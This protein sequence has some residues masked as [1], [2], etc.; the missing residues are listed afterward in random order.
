[1]AAKIKY[2][3]FDLG[4]SKFLSKGDSGLAF[5]TQKNVGVLPLPSILGSNF[6]EISPTQIGSGEIGQ[7]LT[8]ILGNLQSGNFVTGSSG[9]KLD[10]IG[11]FEASAGTITGLIV[12]TSINA[13]EG[14]KMTSSG[15]DIYG[16]TILFYDTD[17]IQRGS[18]I[19]TGTPDVFQISGQSGAD[20][21]I[22]AGA[23]ADIVVLDI[24]RPFTDD[25]FDLGT[26][27]REFKDAFFDGTVQTDA[28]RID[29]TP[30]ASGALTASHYIT[31]NM[32]GTLYRI[33]LDEN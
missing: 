7:N 10:A 9:W 12:Q 30:T 28:L 21:C 15:L 22:K 25:T 33:M 27:T 20:L 23:G 17:G 26:P 24:I 3:I 4:F 6:F 19:A 16:E 2:D 8:M 18:M 32:N 29:Q 1:M 31:V 5:L 13:N 14:V 11:N